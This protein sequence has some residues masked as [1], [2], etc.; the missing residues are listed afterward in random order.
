MSDKII[1]LYTKYIHK[2]YL[3]S[4]HKKKFDSETT[5]KDAYI[6]QRKYKHYVQCKPL[7]KGH[8]SS[9]QLNK[10][11]YKVTFLNSVVTG[12]N[13]QQ[14]IYKHSNTYNGDTWFH[15]I[16]NKRIYIYFAQLKHH[17]E[18]YKLF[19]FLQL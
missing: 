18:K 14:A 17:Q 6:T 4:Q 16:N 13:R 8:I 11:G 3:I 12:S 1:L 10:G 15:K 5:F 2:E 19:Y 7:R 9:L